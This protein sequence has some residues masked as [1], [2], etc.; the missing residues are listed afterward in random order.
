MELTEDLLFQNELYRVMKSG[1]REGKTN[2]MASEDGDPYLLTPG[3]LTT[4]TSVKRA[5]LHD[6]GSRDE[7]L[8]RINQGICECLL[9]LVQAKQTHSCV[10]IQGSGTFAV[11]AMIGSLVPRQGKVLV[12]VNGAYGHRIAEIC[13]YLARDF[14]VE[15]WPENEAVEALKVEQILKDDTEISH[16]TIVYCETTSGLLNPLEEV[17]TVV[18][19]Q[20]RALLIDAMSA[21]GALPI[22][23]RSLPFTALAASSNKCLQG[24]PGMGFCIVLREMLKTCEGNA[25]SLSLDLYRQATGFEQNGQW[26]FTP[27]VQCLLALE[28]ALKELQEE[29]GVEARY[30]RYSENCRILKRAMQEMGFECYLQDDLQAPIIVT[31][32]LPTVDGFDFGKL[33]HSLSDKGFIIYPGKITR[34]QTFRIGCIGAISSTQMQAAVDAIKGSLAELGWPGLETVG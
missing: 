17:A 13:R 7:K 2:T 27:P 3:P 34:E 5:T 22:N 4:S 14:L 10:P 33:Y 18:A 20:G 30:Q 25:H 8:I 24:I 31:F 15:E 19:E 1:K 11:E 28:Q 21:F 26:R 12:L 29:G 6:Y 32:K 16:V 9:E 23:A